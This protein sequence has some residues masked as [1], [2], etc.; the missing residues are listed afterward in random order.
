[1]I[2]EREGMIANWIENE[3]DLHV[4]YDPAFISKKFVLTNREARYYCQKFVDKGKLCKIKIENSI[5]YAKAEW[6][7]QLRQY[8]ALDDVKI[9]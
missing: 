5:Y 2:N 6:Y 1:M 3:W 8:N 4:I 9:T 7:A